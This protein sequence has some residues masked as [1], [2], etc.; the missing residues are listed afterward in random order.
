MIHWLKKSPM[1][2]YQ[3]STNPLGIIDPILDPLDDLLDS[4]YEIFQN[5]TENKKEKTRFFHF[6]TIK[7]TNHSYS[8][9]VKQLGGYLS[10]E[11]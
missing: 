6:S 11:N 5:K 2:K 8:T 1:Y 9:H 10:S 4:L 3:L 7:R